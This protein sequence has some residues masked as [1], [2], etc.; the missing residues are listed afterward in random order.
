MTASAAVVRK[1][2]VIRER[3]HGKLKFIAIAGI[4]LPFSFK[5]KVPPFA[6]RQKYKYQ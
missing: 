4:F 3:D 5:K 2:A 1:E 6:K